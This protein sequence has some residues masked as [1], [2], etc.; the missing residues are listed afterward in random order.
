MGKRKII[1]RESVSDSIASVAWFI[2]SKGL[3]ATADKF[4]DDAYDFIENLAND[5]VVHAPC[6]DPERK[7]LGLKCIAYKKKYTIVFFESDNEIIVCEFI[8]SKLIQW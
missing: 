1:I 4:T 5:I 2:E 7:D 3:V 8:A 6:R